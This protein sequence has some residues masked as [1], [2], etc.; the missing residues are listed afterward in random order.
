MRPLLKRGKIAIA[1]RLID[2]LLNIQNPA[3]KP[4]TLSW[5]IGGGLVF[6]IAID[7]R[8]NPNRTAEVEWSHLKANSRQIAARKSDQPLDIQLYFFT[9]CRTPDECSLQK[10][11]AQIQNPLIVH[12]RSSQWIEGFIFEEQP[13]N[14]AV[15]DIEHGLAVFGESV[16]CFGIADRLTFVKTIDISAIE[17][18]ARRAAVALLER[19]SHAQIPITQ[20][21]D[22]F[23]AVVIA[24]IESALGNF[25]FLIGIDRLYCCVYS[26][27]GR[28]GL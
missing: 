24:D 21:K 12:E 5:I 17:S 18:A 14:F 28:V 16:S 3:L 15:G 7:D 11:L 8:F 1:F 26:C 10:T 9:L 20:G 25:P 27:H 6:D 4:G 22:R 2:F 13:D 23:V 19:A